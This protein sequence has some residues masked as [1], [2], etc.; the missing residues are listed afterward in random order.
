MIY[1]GHPLGTER[2][3]GRDGLM[4]EFRRC[5]LRSGVGSA[6]VTRST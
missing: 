3:R 6:E 2:F 4:V 1:T 5:G